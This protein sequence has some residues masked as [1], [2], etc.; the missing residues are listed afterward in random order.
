MKTVI[1][2]VTNFIYYKDEYLLLERNKNKKID[3]NKINGVGGKLEKG[4][5]F[6]DAVIRETKEETGYIIK[7]QDITF[8][9]IIDFEEGYPEEWI[10]GFFRIKVSDKKIPLGNSTGDGQLFWV[11]KNKILNNKFNLVDDLNYCFKDIVKNNG[12]FFITLKLDSNF[13]I[14]KHNISKLRI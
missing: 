7:L 14:I 1:K 3:P 4:E 13:K 11:H 8:S 12:V 5:N 2:S 6:I 9:G 10:T